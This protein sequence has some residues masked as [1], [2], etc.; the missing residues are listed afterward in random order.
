MRLFV[1]AR[2]GESTFN[3]QRRV[4][5]DPG[6]S[7]VLTE[8]GRAQGRRLGLQLRG[9]PIDLCWISRFARVSET[10]ALVL[11]GRGVP[12]QV[13]ARLDDLGLG[14]FEGR[15][16]DT[17]RE[18]RRG[19]GRDEAPPGGESLEAARLRYVQLFDD[20]LARPAPTSLVIGHELSLRYLLNAALG[21]DHLDDPIHHIANA[22]PYIFDENALTVALDRMSRLRD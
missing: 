1:M 7:V 12:L 15:H 19:H 20:L 11:E 10:A 16:A 5:G 13:D 8:S 21:S 9:M 3:V 14:A 18:W 4:N 17:H 22:T 2:H 6:V